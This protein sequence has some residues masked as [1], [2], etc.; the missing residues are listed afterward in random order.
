MPDDVEKNSPKKIVQIN[1][2]KRALEVQ[3]EIPRKSLTFSSN[4]SNGLP[5][6][7]MFKIFEYFATNMGGNV[8]ELNNLKDVC[9]YWSYVA[10][11][12]KLWFKLKMSALTSPKFV[13]NSDK[14]KLEKNASSKRDFNLFGIE[15]KNRIDSAGF[16][17]KLKFVVCLNLSNLVYLS[18]DGLELVLSHCDP[19]KLRELD[20]SNCQKLS[21]STKGEQYENVLCLYCPNIR[22]LNL[23]SMG[24]IKIYYC[25]QTSAHEVSFVSVDFKGIFFK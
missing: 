16:A 14:Y 4:W 17:E 10:N 11:D 13:M 3:D 7:I 23:K 5:Y 1:K 9:K 20:V 19:A 6:E 18:C 25:I 15:L 8:R 21:V 22:K 2:K 24:V 12:N